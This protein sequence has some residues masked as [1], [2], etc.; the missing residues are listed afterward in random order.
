MDIPDQ[1]ATQLKPNCTL[2]AI[3]CSSL[4]LSWLKIQLQSVSVCIDFSERTNA[5]KKIVMTV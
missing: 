2:R 1:K 3:K 4:R 5:N